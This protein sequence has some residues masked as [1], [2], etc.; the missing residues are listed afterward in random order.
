MKFVVF[1]VNVVNKTLNWCETVI[2]VG[3]AIS[4]S[5]MGLCIQGDLYSLSEKKAK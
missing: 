3:M 5:V 2:R 4:F 1:L